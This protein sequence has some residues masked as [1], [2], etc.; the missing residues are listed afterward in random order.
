MA[1]RLA[2]GPPELAAPMHP[3]QV[4]FA[5]LRA[6]I[7]RGA[8]HRALDPVVRAGVALRARASERLAALAE[9]NARAPWTAAIAFAR[10]AQRAAQRAARGG[11]ARSGSGTARTVRSNPI[12]RET[13]MRTASPSPAA[14]R[15]LRQS[16]SRPYSAE[17]EKCPLDDAGNDPK[18]PEPVA[19]RRLMRLTPTTALAPRST[20]LTC[21]WVPRIKPTGAARFRRAALPGSH[22][23]QASPVGVAAALRGGCVQQFHAEPA[24]ACR[25]P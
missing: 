1:A 21:T 14:P 6:A 2:V 19:A 16:A 8:C 11:A 18:Q 20:T 23:P 5:K 7:L 13:A 24:R 15:A 9:A 10:A 3:S 4:A 12:Q 22:M 25:R 17:R